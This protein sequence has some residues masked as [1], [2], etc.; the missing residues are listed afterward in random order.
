[1]R[2]A[3]NDLGYHV[4][5]KGTVVYKRKKG[6]AIWKLKA[7]ARIIDVFKIAWEES[8]ED[9]RLRLLNLDKAVGIAQKERNDVVKPVLITI[10]LAT[11]FLGSI[12]TWLLK[13]TV[14]RI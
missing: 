10:R 6:I 3:L 9:A 14:D 12:D 7:I 1:M 5:K 8:G 2:S 11:T 13:W 4:T